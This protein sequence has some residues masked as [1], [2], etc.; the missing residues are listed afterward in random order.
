MQFPGKVGAGSLLRQNIVAAFD[1]LSPE[2]S[3]LSGFPSLSSAPTN[4]I[5]S[6][7]ELC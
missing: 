1:S 2:S 7:T 3:P 6:N 5:V 4:S